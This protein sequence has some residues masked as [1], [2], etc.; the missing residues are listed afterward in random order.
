MKKPFDEMHDWTGEAR[1]HY[2]IFSEWLKKQ[3]PDLMNLKRSEADL[4]FRKVG[5]TFAVYGDEQGA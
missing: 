1:P 3:N 5:I 4:I 2:K